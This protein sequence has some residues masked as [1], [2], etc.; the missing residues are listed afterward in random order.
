MMTVADVIVPTAF[1]KFAGFASSRWTNVLL[2]G[3][4]AAELDQHFSILSAQ[5]DDLDLRL[6]IH[7]DVLRI[8][9]ERWIIGVRVKSALPALCD[10]VQAILRRENEETSSKN[11]NTNCLVWF[12]EKNRKNNDNDSRIVLGRTDDGYCLW[13]HHLV[14]AVRVQVNGGQK[15]SLTRMCLSMKVMGASDS[16]VNYI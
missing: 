3:A 15:S 4:V 5:I 13:H 11:N 1:V 9:E 7:F 8:H 14:G 12:R 2:V 16:L 10:V 6:G